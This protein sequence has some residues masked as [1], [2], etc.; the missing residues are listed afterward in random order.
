MQINAGVHA[1][2]LFD[3]WAG[4]LAPDDYR[5]FALPYAEKV[6]K[7]IDKKGV[8][9]IYFANG[10]S[11]ILEFMAASGAD[12]VGLDWRVDMADAVRRSGRGGTPSGKFGPCV[13]FWHP[14][15][16]K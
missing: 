16:V 11:G 10:V 13:F 12:V 8:P 4:W 6:I 14:T 7:G 1:V 15:F 3:T 2:Q 5:E 9:V